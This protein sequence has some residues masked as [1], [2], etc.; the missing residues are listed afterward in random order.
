MNGG[1]SL[2]IEF[3]KIFFYML[4]ASLMDQAFNFV[5]ICYFNSSKEFLLPA[6]MLAF[7][8][9]LLFSSFFASST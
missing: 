7:F 2:C 6:G 5:T 8:L 9:P 4:S 3:C 1:K